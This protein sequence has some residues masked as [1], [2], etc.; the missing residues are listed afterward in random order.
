MY[1]RVNHIHC[2]CL[3]CHES[4]QLSKVNINLFVNPDYLSNFEHRLA[5][6]QIAESSPHMLDWKKLILFP[7]RGG[8]GSI[9]TYV[10]LPIIRTNKISSPYDFELMRFDCKSVDIV[11]SIANCLQS[12]PLFLR[13]SAFSHTKF[14]GLFNH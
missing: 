6:A 4:L 2:V 3:D 12:N 5:A 8:G 13:H 1:T 14:L 10:F 9:Y 11:F 7:L